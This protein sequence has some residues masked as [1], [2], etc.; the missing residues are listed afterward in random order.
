MADPMIDVDD[1]VMGMSAALEGQP[2]EVQGA[3]LADCL[4]LWLA[5]HVVRGDPQATEAL[6]EE[7]LALHLKAVRMLIP[8]NY[9]ELIEPRL[10]K[11]RQ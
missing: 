11:M 4:A 1:V 2:E 9:H 5:G 7:M 3:A 8:V 6:R 10:R